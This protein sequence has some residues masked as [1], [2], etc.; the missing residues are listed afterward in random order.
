MKV[1]LV[2]LGL[3][4]RP[5]VWTIHARAYN[6]NL[7]DGKVS[8]KLI[9]CSRD[10]GFPIWLQWCVLR[11]MKRASKP[12]IRAGKAVRLAVPR[13]VMLVTLLA[14]SIQTYLTQTH[15]HWAQE[16][17]ASS[18]QVTAGKI[19]GSSSRPAEPKDRYPANEDPANCPLCQELIHAGQFVTPTTAALLLP[20]LSVSII[21]IAV[22]SATLV[23][24]VSHIWRGRA[25]PLG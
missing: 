2:S 19:A 14:F 21:E 17:Q 9:R 22:P 11:A 8:S 7:A 12:T 24:A 16:R 18:Q 25:P 4:W 6:R 23:R 13:V 15:I 10:F 20:F 1:P 5:S 3:A